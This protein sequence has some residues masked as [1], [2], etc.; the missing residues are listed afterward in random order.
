MG[1]FRRSTLLAITTGIAVGGVVSV[2]QLSGGETQPVVQAAQSL[3]G[4]DMFRA[5]AFGQGALAR[6]LSGRPALRDV[7]RSEYAANNSSEQVAAVDT[8]IQKIAAEDPSYFPNFGN[9][10]RSGDPFTVSDVLGGVASEIKKVGGSF[11][12][13]SGHPLGFKFNFQ[14]QFNITIHTDTAFILYNNVALVNDYFRMDEPGASGMSNDFQ[15]QLVVGEITAA[16][17]S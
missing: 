10:L 13:V 4:Q 15:R 14:W 17:K 9:A 5:I 2:I 6:E 1:N 11:E 3:S 12:K 16:L 7:Y 8:I